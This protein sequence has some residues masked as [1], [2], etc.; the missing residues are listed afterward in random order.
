MVHAFKK[1]IKV[2]HMPSRTS[3]I[4]FKISVTVLSVFIATS[5]MYPVAY[6]VAQA[7]I[8]KP[9][10]ILTDFTQLIKYGFTLENFNNIL[11]SER[12][13]Q[14]LTTT[15][16]V[17]LITVVLAITVI[18]PAAYAFSR[19]GF[20]GKDT[21]L[22]VYLIVSQAGG[23][24][25]I[26]SILALYMFLMRLQAYGLRLISPL[27]LPFIYTA[28]LVPFQTWLMKSYFDQLPKELD[29]AAFV[30][31]A[32][33]STIVFRVILPASRAAFIIISLFAFMSAWGEFIIANIMGITTLGKF[34]FE[35]AAGQAGVMEPATFAAGAIV[36][37]VPIV[38]LFVLAQKYIGEAYKLG[39]AKG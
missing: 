22:Y 34:I 8:G 14:A 30:D 25:G 38:V 11:R 24:L 6:I 19:F 23:G 20:K 37:A 7:L 15:L 3:M 26:I 2:T 28:G 35:S 4:I 13:Y 12:F 32:N 31:G 21:V 5:L 10:I 18:I 1:T 33:W 9:T 16:I 27:T 17:A 36:Y 29:E 39:I